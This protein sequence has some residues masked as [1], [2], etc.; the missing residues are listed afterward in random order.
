MKKNKK[1]T[2]FKLT[3]VKD[4][5]NPLVLEPVAFDL[6]DDSYGKALKG[7]FGNKL[8]PEHTKEVEGKN[9][10]VALL[11]AKLNARPALPAAMSSGRRIILA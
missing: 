5:Q 11:L 2:E 1:Q 6:D 4:R 7:H 9:T 10:C 8:L 3:T